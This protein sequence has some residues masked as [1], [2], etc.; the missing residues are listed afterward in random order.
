MYYNLVSFTGDYEGSLYQ[1]VNENGWVTRYLDSQ[2]EPVVFAPGTITES[3]VIGDNV[4]VPFTPA[5]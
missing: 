1:E 2:G 3:S 5:V 4:E